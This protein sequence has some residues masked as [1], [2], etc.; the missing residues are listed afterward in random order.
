M[1][2]VAQV[3]QD[4]VDAGEVMNYV[5]ADA[6]CPIGGVRAGMDENVAIIRES[7]VSIGGFNANSSTCECLRYNRPVLPP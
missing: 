2:D 4:D 5:N 3:S 7:S 1:H 6:T